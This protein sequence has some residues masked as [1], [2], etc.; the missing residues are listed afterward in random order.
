MKTNLDLNVIKYF[1]SVALLMF[2]RKDGG[3]PYTCEEACDAVDKIAE[4]HA[5][6]TEKEDDEWL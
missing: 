6:K 3:K 2:G 1:S 5:P 4:H